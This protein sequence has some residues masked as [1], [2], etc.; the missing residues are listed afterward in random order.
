MIPVWGFYPLSMVKLGKDAIIQ[1]FAMNLETE[2][3]YQGELVE[4]DAGKE[5][6]MPFNEPELQPQALEERLLSAYFNRK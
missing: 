6:S 3:V 5:E 1:L 2:Q 4:E